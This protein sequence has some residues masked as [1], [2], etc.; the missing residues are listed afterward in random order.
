MIYPELIPIAT[1]RKENSLI[2]PNDIH[3]RKLFFFVC[4]KIHNV[5]IV[6][7]GLIISTNATKITSGSAV[8]FQKLTCDPSNTKKII[9][10]KSLNGLILLVISNLYGE[11]AKL[12][13]AINVP[14]SIPNHNR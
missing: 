8:I 3:V 2:C 12:I 13:H 11:L 9:I 4:H 14:I 7:I 6:I 10:K 1:K 5:I